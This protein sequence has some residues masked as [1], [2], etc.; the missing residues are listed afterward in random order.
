MAKPRGRPFD[1]SRP[2]PGR[3]KGAQNKAK[4]EFNQ[5][6]KAIADDPDYK[7][8]VRARAIKGDPNLDR[9]I[10]DRILGPVKNVHEVN[11][12]RPLVIDVVNGPDDSE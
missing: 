3:P 11:V 6:L 2:G 1:G 12:P 10:F 7:E 4:V 8:S 9:Q 5:L